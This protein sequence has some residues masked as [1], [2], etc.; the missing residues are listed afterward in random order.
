MEELINLKLESAVGG[1]PSLIPPSQRNL[2][3]FDLL[4][5]PKKSPV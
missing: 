2:M 1:E 5:H 3:I 4:T